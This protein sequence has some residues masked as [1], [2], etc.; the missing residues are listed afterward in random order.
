MAVS[1]KAGTNLMYE[2]GHVN[3]YHDNLQDGSLT[4]ED[5]NAK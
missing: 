1:V 2:G 3:D 4:E 5:V